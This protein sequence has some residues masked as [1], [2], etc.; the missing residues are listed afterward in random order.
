MGEVTVLPSVVVKET[1]P[2]AA[3]MTAVTQQLLSVPG[4]S[5][6]GRAS[7]VSVPAAAPRPFA[8]AHWSLHASAGPSAGPGASDWWPIGFNELMST[9]AAD[10]PAN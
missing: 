4:R 1:F 10:I 9:V 5:D 7:N 8:P 3:L 6:S 2:P